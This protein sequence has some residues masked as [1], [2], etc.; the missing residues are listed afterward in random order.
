MVMRAH[1]AWHNPFTLH[2]FHVRLRIFGNQL[3]AHLFDMR[4]FNRNINTVLYRRR[5]EL[6]RRNIF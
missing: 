5:F 4:T 6:N 3:A 2:I 1:N